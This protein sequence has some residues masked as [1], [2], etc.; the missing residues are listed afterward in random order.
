MDTRSELCVPLTTKAGV[1][2][3]L[4]VQSDQ[5][6]AFDP[7]D[8]VVLQSLAHQAAI[9]IDNARLYEQAQQLA[10][11][12]E[13][14]RLGRE[15]HDAVT[16]TLFS[17]SLIAEVL[18]RLWERDRDEGRRRLDELGQLTRG[19]LAEM[20]ALLLELRP[21]AL[22]EG[23]LADLLRQLAEATTGR[24][25]V[26]VQVSV[27][28]ECSLPPDV[29]VALYR[30][31]QEALNNVARHSGGSQA[32]L[33]LSCQSERVEL[34]VTDRGYGF[35]VDRLSAEGMGLGIM[36]ERA[37]DIGAEFYIHSQPG[38]GTRISVVWPDPQRKGSQ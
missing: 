9:A 23:S 22:A 16:Q 28:G 35:D 34:A 21:G 8:V 31:A 7:F 5:L 17:A 25:L 2:G 4:D 1:I 29:Q 37:E 10:A 13:R 6:D 14:E 26:P 24:V 27:E 30:I 19:A 15:L 32:L 18:P 11:L 12:E 3:V 33:E 20:R 36:R 38:K